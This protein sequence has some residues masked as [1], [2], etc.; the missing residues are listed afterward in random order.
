M[1]QKYFKKSKFYCIHIYCWSGIIETEKRKLKL[2]S[3]LCDLWYATVRWRLSFYQLLDDEH[4]LV[5][6]SVKTDAMW[7]RFVTERLFIFFS[8]NSAYS[9]G[10][11]KP[12]HLFIYSFIYTLD[13]IHIDQ[14]DKI[15]EGIYKSMRKS[16][17]IAKIGTIVLLLLKSITQAKFFLAFSYSYWQL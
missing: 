3:K 6:W 1:W 9:F 16:V 10:E 17:W 14:N 7:V 13:E 12:I 5:P 2:I 11:S 4:D 8:I 15:R